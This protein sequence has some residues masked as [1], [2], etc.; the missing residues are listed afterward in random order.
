MSIRNQRITVSFMTLIILIFG[1]FDKT[2]GLK[3]TDIKPLVSR[4]LTRHVQYHEL[5]DELSKRTFRN[6]I[7]YLDPGKYYFYDMDVK[8]FSVYEEEI[9][10]FIDS[11]NYDIIF[12]IFDLYKKRFKE[13]NKLFKELIT[14][15]Y[16]FNK[17]ENI[18]TDRDK[19][20]YPVNKNDM[21]ERWRKNIKLQLLNYISIVKDIKK[22]KEKLLKKYSLQEKRVEEMNYE[23]VIAIF[24]NAFSTALDP[25]SNYLTQEDHEDFMISTKLKL[26]GIG[27]LLR[28]EDG[29]VKVE[30]IIPGGAASKL[31]E[32]LK[33]KPNDKIIAVAQGSE[34]P[35]D[36]IDMDL[37]E[38][39]K[40]IRGKKGTEVRLTIIREAEVTGKQSRLEIPIIREEIKLEDR[41]AKSDIYTFKNNKKEIKIGY[42]KLPSFYRDFDAIQDNKP[43]A[44][45]SS[46]D[47]IY[48]IN[49]LSNKGIH[50]MVI[51]LRGNPG[52]ALD[53]AIN[54]AGIFIDQGP[55]VQIKYSNEYV[56]ELRD[57]IPDVYYNGPIVVLIDKFSASASEIF[58]GAIKD[59][60]RGIIIGPSST[61]GKGSVQSYEVLSNKKG[62]IKITTALF[63]QPAGTSNQVNGIYPDITVPDISSIWEIGESKLKYP[64]TWEK[65]KRS[66]YKPYNTYMNRKIVNTLKAHSDKRIRTDKK[67]KALIEKIHKLKKKISNK[68]I[69]LKEES[70]L[71]EQKLKQIE[72][73]IKRER[74]EK[75]ID[76]ERDVFLQEAFHITAEYIMLLQ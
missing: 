74:E 54:L 70:K 49:T 23:K 33:L 61:F 75:I 2:N 44:K 59:Y 38:V 47:V 19:I 14:N 12:D 8:K 15:K 29:F 42:I 26:E 51:D 30:S 35:V 40:L 43:D 25:H 76:I 16:D 32:V 21:K 28:S 48:H 45:S 3:Q 57:K 7:K 20:G 50:G 9:D 10:A 27:A 11:G 64:I 5:N 41:A 24:V 63:Y 55:I 36:V 31:P 73:N 37:R 65:L 66:H 58:A 4:F 22:A 62:A 18:Q 17:D 39:V 69:S 13:N 71:E 67:F 6:Y 34:E 52:G 46:T 56:E 60:K 1:C 72:K 68:T 53:E